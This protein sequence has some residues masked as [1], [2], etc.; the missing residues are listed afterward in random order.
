MKNR[1][2]ASFNNTTKTNYINND[3][4]ILW[5]NE[6]AEAEL[7]ALKKSLLKAEEAI[8][9]KKN[10]II[11]SETSLKRASIEYEKALSNEVQSKQNLDLA[12]KAEKVAEAAIQK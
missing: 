6:Q 11:A 1:F 2:F 3:H 10:A 4:D 8:T 7:E 5:W 12:S 9:A